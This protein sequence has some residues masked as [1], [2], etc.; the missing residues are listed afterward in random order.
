MIG[1]KAR[2]I[3]SEPIGIHK[4]AWKEIPQGALVIVRDGEV[5]VD[6]FTPVES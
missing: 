4:E 6:K 2:A 3:V 5:K 1:S